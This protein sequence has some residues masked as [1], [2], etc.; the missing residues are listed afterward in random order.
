MERAEKLAI[1][2]KTM[3]EQFNAIHNSITSDN[4]LLSELVVKRNILDK[5]ISDLQLK[6]RKDNNI[7]DDLKEIISETKASYDNISEAANTLMDIIDQK[8][9]I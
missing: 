4:K 3:D 9:N 7:M 5:Q 2:I 8:Y 6:L 1:K